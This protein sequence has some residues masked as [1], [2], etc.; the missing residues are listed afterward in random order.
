MLERATIAKKMHIIFSRICMC[1]DIFFKNIVTKIDISSGECL[2]LIVMPS[3]ASEC[4]LDWSQ[5]L[6]EL[7]IGNSVLVTGEFTGLFMGLAISS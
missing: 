4:S 5:K 6:S 7:A 2:V 3:I 1:A